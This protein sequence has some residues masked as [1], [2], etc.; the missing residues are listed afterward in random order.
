[1]VCEFQPFSEMARLAEAVGIIPLPSD[2]PRNSFRGR[3]RICATATE[4]PVH[5]RSSLEVEDGDLQMPQRYQSSRTHNSHHAME[6]SK[7]RLDQIELFQQC[8]PCFLEALSHQL[9][10]AVFDKGAAIIKQGDIGTDMFLLH[11]GEV[12]V[13]ITIG[14]RDSVVATLGSGSLFGEMAAI[15]K[16]SMA[17]KRTATVRAKTMCNCWRIDRSSLL[18]LFSVY[19]KDEA[20]ISAEAERR[21]HDLVDKGLISLPD[22]KHPFRQERTLTKEEERRLSMRQERRLSSLAQR[23]LQKRKT[24]NVLMKLGQQCVSEGNSEL[25]ADNH[26]GSSSDDASDYGIERSTTIASISTVDLDRASTMYSL[27]VTGFTSHRSADDGR[28]PRCVLPTLDL[29][30]YVAT[31]GSEGTLS[32]QSPWS[33]GRGSSKATVTSGSEGTVGS[34]TPQSSRRGSS[35]CWRIGETHEVKKVRSSVSSFLAK[36]GIV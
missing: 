12:Q 29:K 8:N 5:R 4:P 31:F 34:Q 20:V 16:N 3:R 35:T 26:S 22:L 25:K 21:F 32:T 24:V 1:V 14:E 19:P 30:A 28:S 13:E 11:F 7:P 18:K 36:R 10:I 15:C 33:S 2:A 17:A 27:A 6:F 9:D 23:S